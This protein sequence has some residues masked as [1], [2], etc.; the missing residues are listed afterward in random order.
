MIINKVRNKKK[1]ITIQY[2]IEDLLKSFPDF[3]SYKEEVKD[4]SERVIILGK[5]I[6]FGKGNRN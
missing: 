6:G 5:L 4:L 1:N 2:D 3:I